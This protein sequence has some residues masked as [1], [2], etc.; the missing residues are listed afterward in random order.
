MP[1]LLWVVRDH[2]LKFNEGDKTADDYLE[3]VLRRRTGGRVGVLRP[4]LPR[5][6]WQSLV[7]QSCGPMHAHLYRPLR[8]VSD[9]FD[10]ETPLD[11]RVK[12]AI[13]SFFKRRGCAV[14]SEPI[15]PL[16]DLKVS[17]C[18]LLAGA[19]AFCPRLGRLIVTVHFV[20]HLYSTSRS[21]ST[22]SFCPRSRR[23]APRSLRAFARFRSRKWSRR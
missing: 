2:H 21:A 9:P 12:S 11:D 10:E 13:S 6:C 16:S 20:C 18:V 4:S 5:A 23:S 14:I 8:F 7:F 17:V 19:I 22:S 15:T 3:S 1:D